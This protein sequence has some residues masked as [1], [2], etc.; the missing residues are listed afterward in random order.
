MVRKIIKNIPVFSLWIA[1]LA[2][3]THLIIPHDHHLVESVNNQE[4]SC[5]ATNGETGHRTGF[6]IHCHAFND[7]A[8]EK[9]TTF[10]LKEHI[11]SIDLSFNCFTDFYVFD[12]QKSLLTVSDFREPFPDPFLLELY[13]L[14]APPSLS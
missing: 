8:S 10:V 3:C 5:P 2:F 9:A 1:A 12:L 6:P 7:M 11:Q 14:R 4:E 13:Q